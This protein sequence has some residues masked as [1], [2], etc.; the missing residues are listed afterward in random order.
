VLALPAVTGA[1]RYPGGGAH[2]HS[3]DAFPN[4]GDS[5]T[6]PDL[7]AEPPARTVTMT[8]LGDALADGINALVVYN[9]NPAVVCPDTN[10]VTRGL[11][12][13]D[14]FTVVLE[15]MPTDT[16]R[17]ADV[18]LPATTQLEHLDVLWSWGHYYLSLN[19]PAIPPRGET[20]PNTEIFRRLATAMGYDE[21]ELHEDD[22]SLV[23]TYLADCTDEQRAALDTHG[24]VKMPVV[25][26][27]EARVQL[28]SDTLAEIAGVDPLPQGEDPPDDDRLILIT[29][30]SHHFLNSQL[31]NHERLRKAAGGA[32]ALLAPADAA[33]AGIVD[34]AP[35]VLTN[36]H[37]TLELDAS[38]SD[39]VLEGTVVVL[40]NWW[41]RDVRRGPGVNALTGQAP[42]D[43]GAA[44]VFT[45]RVQIS[46]A[47]A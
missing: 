25:T 7:R 36:E 33:A 31:V 16:M 41:H 29:P 15:L 24:Y 4:R 43:L 28:R 18:V 19:R 5:M 11:A 27:P 21:P 13:D 23:A 35:A 17:Y 9:S 42:A 46:P 8:G 2:V 30:K 10:S 45:A 37:G 22:E 40:D 6:R 3:A 47:K 39:A 34:G 26:A 12:R 38:V 32:V 44:P 20:L 1:W 14:L